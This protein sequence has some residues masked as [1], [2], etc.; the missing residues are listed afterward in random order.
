MAAKTDLDES[1]L[2]AH[3]DLVPKDTCG[4]TGNSTPPDHHTVSVVFLR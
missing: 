1:Y 3:Y 2:D 4:P